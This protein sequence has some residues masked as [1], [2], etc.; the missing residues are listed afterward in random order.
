MTGKEG[1]GKLHRGPWRPRR[2]GETR[3]KQRNRDAA[4]HRQFLPAALEVQE[5]PPSPA[6]RSLLWLLLALF[7]A[8]LL[9]AVFGRV[10]IVVSAP[11]RV[12]PNGQVKV[13]QAPEAGTVA[14]IH[15]REGERVEAGQLLISLDPTFAS[16]DDTRLD[17][18]RAH[19]RLQLHWRDAL[20][21][22]LAN[23]REAATA[24]PVLRKPVPAAIAHTLAA[25]VFSR[26]RDEITARLDGFARELGASR[27]EQ[28]S[29]EAE[30]AKAR[31]T[32]A[33]LE[34]RVDA[35]ET[36]VKRQYGARIEYLE[37]LQQQTELQQSLPV[38]RSR[39]QQVRER[40][41]AITA[42]MRAAAED[43]R[44]KN[45]LEVSRL[46]AERATLRQEARK[47]ARREQ[48][49]LVTAPVTGTV[50]ELALHTVG[51][52][53]T[54]AQTL[55][56]LVPEGA[57]VQVEAMLQNRDV[58]FVRE[59]QKAEVKV[60]AFNFTKYG[61]LRAQVLDISDDAVQDE[62]TGWV[63]KMRLSLEQDS[64]EVQGRQVRLS[65]GMSVVTEVKTGR[66]RLI[67]F[68]LSPLLRYR[69]ESLRER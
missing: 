41:A 61:L 8:G 49:L 64:L 48:Q 53:V 69:Q 15:V 51:G 2:S 62:Q 32:L 46:E 12:V 7:C 52:V 57:V 54:P 68:F 43:A 56:K 40:A 35:Y 29:L 14:R 26:H 34:E 63:F 44:R 66:R 9:W 33:I 37:M 13:V 58:G 6:G 65:P 4:L 3:D 31:A 27:A 22:W 67:E 45:L 30:E 50:Q 24:L 19:V 21:R 55:M 18:K 16:A 47:A 17:E 10:D 11:G 36:L 42:R 23:G 60:D 1:D 38:L 20:E 39:Q 59:G 25:S 5:K 28:R